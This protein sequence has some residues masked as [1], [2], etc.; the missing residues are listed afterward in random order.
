M[1][2]HPSQAQTLHR[3]QVLDISLFDRKTKA[4]IDA[5]G[6]NFLLKFPRD[7]AN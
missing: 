5:I 3:K 7:R 6:P 1:D 2:L 4:K